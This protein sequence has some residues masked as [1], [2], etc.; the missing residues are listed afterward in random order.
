MKA[1]AD[2]DRQRFQ[3]HG[4]TYPTS[5]PAWPTCGEHD[6]LSG[7]P[8]WATPNIDLG[9]D[10]TYLVYLPFFHANAQTWSFFPVLGVGAT[11]VLMPKWSGAAA[12][13]SSSNTASPTSPC[14]RSSSH[15]AYG[16]TELIT[17]CIAGKPGDGL[18]EQVIGRVTPGYEIAIVDQATGELCTDGRSGELWVR[19]TRGIQLFLEYDRNPEA[20][21]KSFV[22]GWFRTGDILRT[23]DDGQIVYVERDNDL[24]KVGGEN[25]S[26]KE[27]RNI[28]VRHPAIQQAAVVAH[29]DDFLDEVPVAFVIATPQAGTTKK[30]WPSKI[31]RHLQRTTRIVQDPPPDRLRLLV[32]HRHPRQDPQE[33]AA[34]NGRTAPARRRPRTHAQP[35]DVDIN[36]RSHMSFENKF[37]ARL[38]DFGRSPLHACLR[39]PGRSRADRSDKVPIEDL[40]DDRCGRCGLD[41]GH[42]ASTEAGAGQAGPEDAGSLLRSPDEHVDL[43]RTDLVVVPKAR[44]GGRRSARRGRR[45]RHRRRP[46]RR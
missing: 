9:P 25:V 26:A 14:C 45:R 34:N 29:P 39:S 3:M 41:H 6:A 5:S 36:E 19:A 18:K 7:R 23:T 46:R 20:N 12:G 31:L 10:S 4:R 13:P 16:M 24:L 21:E 17:H 15:H 37:L 2:E 30:P 35:L 40:L 22:D 8:R 38:F 28:I 11:A 1:V 42:D 33:R 43:G 32:P 44:M 27:V